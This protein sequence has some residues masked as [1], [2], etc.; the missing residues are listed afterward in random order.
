M[1]KKPTNP[2][3]IDC[4]VTILHL[5]TIFHEGN[6]EQVHQEELCDEHSAP[7]SRE[8]GFR[9]MNACLF[10]IYTYHAFVQTINAIW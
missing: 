2:W 1:I 9:N 10:H 8:S 7:R 5:T 6:N 4:G 3:R